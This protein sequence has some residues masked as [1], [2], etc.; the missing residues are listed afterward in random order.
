MFKFDLKRRECD[1]ICAV[2]VDRMNYHRDNATAHCCAGCGKAEGGGLVS[3]KVCKSCMLA[4][5]CNA[6]CQRKHWPTHKADCKI[7]AAK[8]RDEALFKEPPPKED[9]PICFLPLPSRLICCVSLPPATISSVPIYDFAGANEELADEATEDCYPCCGKTI[10]RGCIYSS[11]K[12]G[13]TRKCPFCNS[14]RGSK[15]NEEMVEEMMKRVEANDADSICMLADSYYQGLNGLQQDQTKAMELYARAITLGCSEAHGK[16]GG[17]YHEGGDMKK[18]KFHCE[19]A[20]MAGHEVARFNLGSM[21]DNSGNMERAIKHWAIGASAGC[22]RAMH[23]LIT[24]FKQGIGSRESIDSTLAAYNAS[25]A[26]MRSE[27]RDAF[28]RIYL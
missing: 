5:Y 20:A 23:A 26:E 27:A 9:C 8:I 2:A 25:S 16:L 4:K 10:C 1:M 11:H 7:Q 21:E 3:L 13:N 22:Y 28:I 24:F 19:A 15:T 17:I 18:A 14:D 12:S 6:A